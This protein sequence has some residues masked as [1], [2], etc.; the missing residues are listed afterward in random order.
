[1][2]GGLDGGDESPRTGRTQPAER[3]GSQ[4]VITLFPRVITFS[5]KTPLIFQSARLAVQT[6]ANPVHMSRKSI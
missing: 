4:H 2:G 1:L 3:F 5:R 6:R